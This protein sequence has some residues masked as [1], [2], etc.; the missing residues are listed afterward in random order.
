M[1][2]YQTYSDERLLGLLRDGDKL[3]FTV[4]FDRY[5][6]LLYVYAC[7]II[8]EEQEA[9]D[10]VQEVFLN[11]WAKKD[12]IE[13]TGALLSYLY[14]SVRYKFF[15]LLDKKKVRSDYAKAMLHFMNE[16]S[17]VTDFQVRE[18]EMLQL[19]EA[20][21]ELLPPKLKQI[22]QLSRQ[23]NM[24][25]G[26]VAAHLNISEKTVKNQLSKAVN[27]LR[28]NLDLAQVGYLLIGTEGFIEILKKI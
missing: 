7:K 12:S 19:I 20:Q 14:Q 1:D 18:K 17:F 5:Q 4:L 28:T 15:N 21:I 3:A 11:L 23:A 9:A 8:R 26:E 27:Q 2:Q 25:T 13:V 16:G 22:Y 24:T 10:I 6:P